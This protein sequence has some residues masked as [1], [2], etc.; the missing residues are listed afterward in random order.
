[1]G[2]K[3]SWFFGQQFPG[4]KVTDPF[5]RRRIRGLAIFLCRADSTARHAEA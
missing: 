1:V 3:S 4:E 5:A 2:K